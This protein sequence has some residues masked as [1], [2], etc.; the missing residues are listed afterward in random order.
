MCVCLRGKHINCYKAVI[1]AFVVVRKSWGR[2]GWCFPK[3]SWLLCVTVGVAST[4]TSELE[5]N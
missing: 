5:L 1:Y 3:L 2:Q 4:C